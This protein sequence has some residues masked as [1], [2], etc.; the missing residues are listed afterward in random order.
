MQLLPQQTLIPGYNFQ[1][2]TTTIF[3]TTLTQETLLVT[4]TQNTSNLGMLRLTA[5][6]MLVLSR[7]ENKLEKMQKLCQALQRQLHSSKSKDHK[8]CSRKVSEELHGL[9]ALSQAVIPCLEFSHQ[10]I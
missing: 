5:K 9:I 2:E 4:S 7:I 10:R 3:H 1:K 6:M 8:A